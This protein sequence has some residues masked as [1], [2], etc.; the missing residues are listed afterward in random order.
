MSEQNALSFEE[1]LQ[2]QRRNTFRIIAFMAGSAIIAS[3]AIISYF[4]LAISPELTSEM[5]GSVEIASLT[6]MPYMISALIAALTAIGVTTLLPYTRY[7]EPSLKLVSSLRSLAEGD[8]TV[9]L[10]L[11][12]DDPMR[13]VANELNYAVANIDKAVTT[14]KVQNRTQWGVLCRIR[15]AAENGDCDDVLHFCKEMEQNWDKVAEIENRLK[16]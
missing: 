9:R 5:L 7:G 15:M 14:L 13:D 10:Q 3:A 4:N 6:F 8:L 11:S 2:S 1:S 12:T 16:T